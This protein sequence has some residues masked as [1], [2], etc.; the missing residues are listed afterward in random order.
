MLL[1]CSCVNTKRATYFNNL[2]DSAVFNKMPVPE[3]IIHRN[4]IL[5][6]NVSSPN[7]DASKL[8]NLSNSPDIKTTT[9]SG[10]VVEPAG[11]LVDQDGNIRFLMLGTMKA[12]GLTRKQL[13]EN[14]R[15]ALLQKNLLLDPV[16]EVRLLNF[17]VTVLGEVTKPTVI[18]VPNE[19][20]TLMEALGLAGDA[21]AFAKRNNVLVIREEDGKQITKRVDL[22]S[23]EIFSSP[24]YYLKSN[25]IVYVAPNRARVA[26]ATRLNQLLPSVISAL[27]IAVIVWD[28][29]KQ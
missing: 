20:I 25:D 17:K 4:D 27:S 13:Q 18:T 9:P 1:F 16:V 6:I 24:Y 23:T 15:S 7:P 11:Y 29:L 22:N 26:S 28:R 3:V 12:E 2:P 19:R 21:T 5:S 10:D 8:F 14:I